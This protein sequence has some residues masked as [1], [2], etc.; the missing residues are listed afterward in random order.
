MK[1]CGLERIIGSLINRSQLIHNGLNPP[2]QTRAD[3]IEKCPDEGLGPI[4]YF[5]LFRYKL[6]GLMLLKILTYW[7]VS[8]LVT[9]V[10][11]IILE[12]ISRLNCAKTS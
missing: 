11:N 2:D 10:Q 4:Y 12:E 5:S 8:K 1:K 6:L 7:S 9:F 3:G